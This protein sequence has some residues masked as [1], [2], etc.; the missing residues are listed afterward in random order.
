MHRWGA[1]GCAVPL[2]LVI[3]TGLILQIKKQWSWVQPPTRVGT[4]DADIT[5]GEILEVA[6][7][8]DQAKISDWKDIDRLDVRPS[9]GIVKVRTRYDHEVQ[10]DLGKRKIVQSEIRRSDWIES[11]HDGSYFG[12]WAKLSVFLLNGL[13]LFGLWFTG[14]YLW[15]LP[16]LARARKRRKSTE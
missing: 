14:L 10:I 6:R 12:D 15:Y 7:S 16:Y 3:I 4:L 8:D 2:L 9:K 13:V 5:L 11:L 1:L